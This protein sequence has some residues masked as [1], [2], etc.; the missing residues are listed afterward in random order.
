[1]RWVPIEGRPGSLADAREAAGAAAELEADLLYGLHTSAPWRSSV[2]F[3]IEAGGVSLPEM[4]TEG[5]LAGALSRAGARGA[6]AIF[7]LDD[8]VPTHGSGNVRKVPAAVSPR[9]HWSREEASRVE[10]ER[11]GL[12]GDYVLAWACS[13]SG[14]RRLL[15]AWTWVDGS[16]GDS[17]ALA[18]LCGNN[19]IRGEA[20]AQASDLDLAESVRP[21]VLDRADGLPSLF[22][23]A[24]AFLGVEAGPTPQI[25][26]WAMASGAAIAAE[27]TPEAEAVT[28]EASYLAAPGDTRALGAAVLTLLVEEEVADRLRDRGLRRAEGYDFDKALAARLQVLRGVKDQTRFP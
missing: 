27:S 4:D 23:G 15:A 26:R 28:G 14:L 24:R 3:V 11:F 2:P 20:E 5:R 22:R 12:R 10:A 19:S 1:M 16:L 21:I 13:R 8:V 25:L 7:L 9:F 17:V 18:L 6:S